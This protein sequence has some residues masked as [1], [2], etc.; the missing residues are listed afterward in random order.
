VIVC[1]DISATPEVTFDSRLD[2]AKL[3]VVAVGDDGAVSAPATFT[4]LASLQGKIDGA[5]PGFS[6]VKVGSSI[7]VS[8]SGWEPHEAVSLTLSDRILQDPYKNNLTPFATTPPT[9]VTTDSQ[10]AFSTAFAIPATL[11]WGHDAVLSA[12]GVGP[13][14]GTLFPPWRRHFTRKATS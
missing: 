12:T 4:Y 3:Y 14:F 2:G 10:G 5:S 7:I 6:G 1:I 8:V 13:H 11:P 9:T